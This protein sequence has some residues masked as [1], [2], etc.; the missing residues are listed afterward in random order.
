MAMR[1]SWCGDPIAESHPM[2]AICRRLEEFGA[3]KQAQEGLWQMFALFQEQH[4]S[5]PT[6]PAEDRS[7][8]QDPAAGGAAGAGANKDTFDAS[9]AGLPKKKGMLRRMSL[10]GG[11]QS[12]G[13]EGHPAGAC[14][15]S[16]LSVFKNAVQKQGMIL[17]SFA[18][19]AAGSEYK[20][21]NWAQ[22]DRGGNRIF[23]NPAPCQIPRG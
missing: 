2:H 16:H 21:S 5:A 11:K 8:F 18:S 13:G 23:A 1:V 20:S 15:S 3:Q 7:G 4:S 9:A 19:C 6:L 14:S 10:K 22:H 17:P 12:G